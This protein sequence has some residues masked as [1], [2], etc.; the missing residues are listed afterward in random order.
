ML[1]S[2]SGIPASTQAFTSDMSSSVRRLSPSNEPCPGSGSHGGIYGSLSQSS[3][4]CPI[5]SHL[6]TSSAQMDPNLR[7]GDNSYSFCRPMEQSVAAMLPSLSMHA[8]SPDLYA[9]RLAPCLTTSPGVQLHA[10][11]LSRSSNRAPCCG[12]PWLT[13]PHPTG[14]PVAVSTWPPHSTQH[15]PLAPRSA[16]SHVVALLPPI[17]TYRSSI[18]PVYAGRHPVA[19]PGTSTETSGVTRAPLI[20][21]SVPATSSTASPSASNAV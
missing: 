19:P 16:S 6:G 15:S 5:A 3:S 10:P 2:P 18:R 8:L 1:P 7:C 20:S 9:K 12:V 17:R 11:G 14:T 13:I 21:T 4:S